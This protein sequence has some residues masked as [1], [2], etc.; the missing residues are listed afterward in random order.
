[1]CAGRLEANGHAFSF[2]TR[3]LAPLAHDLVDLLT[4]CEQAV[5]PNLLKLKEA[6]AIIQQKLQQSNSQKP[7]ARSAH[8]DDTPGKPCVSAEAHE[9]AAA[10]RPAAAQATPKNAKNT[11]NMRKR[12]CCSTPGESGHGSEHGYG[13]ENDRAGRGKGFDT[14]VKAGKKKQNSVQQGSVSKVQDTR[15]NQDKKKKRRSREDN[16]AAAAGLDTGK[17]AKQGILGPPRTELA[18]LAYYSGDNSD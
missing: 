3:N 15:G 9:D 17:K 5:D 7:G 4:R 18:R 14:S 8:F 12:A 6:Y 10:P 11:A 1:M 13:C 16:R 2:I